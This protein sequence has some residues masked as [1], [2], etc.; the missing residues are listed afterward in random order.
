MS[1]P[2]LSPW[3]GP[4]EL[5]PFAAITDADFAP[6]FEQGLAEARAALEGMSP[7]GRLYRPD[8]VTSAALWLCSEGAAGVN[9]Q[10]IVISGG[11]V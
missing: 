8:E 7:Q 2:L 4:F 10:G 5:P 1:N 9:G 3:K 6:A 11:E